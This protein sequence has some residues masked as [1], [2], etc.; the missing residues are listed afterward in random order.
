MGSG[1]KAG[2]SPREEQ[3]NGTQGSGSVS[4][5]ASGWQVIRDNKIIIG[6]QK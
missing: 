2:Q 3:P 4:G 6:K 1:E 5:K